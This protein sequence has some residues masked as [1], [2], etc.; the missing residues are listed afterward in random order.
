MRPAGRGAG[1]GARRAPAFRPP[2]RGGGPPL[3]PAGG[4]RPPRRGGPPPRLSLGQQQRVAFVRCL[5]QPFDFLLLD[6]PVSH[7]D[8]AN[9]ETLASL[10]V[11][12]AR[13]QGAGVLVTS[14]GNRLPLPYHK[15]YRL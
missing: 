7:L 5:C 2:P 15:I 9:G 8:A 1:W 13:R 6:E 14:V 11:E 12:E 3:P 4:V 10:V